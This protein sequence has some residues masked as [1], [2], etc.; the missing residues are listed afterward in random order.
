MIVD[1]KEPRNKNDYMI[2]PEMPTAHLILS[3]GSERNLPL[4]CKALH[5]EMKNSSAEIQA[6]IRQLES[7]YVNISA[8]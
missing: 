6:K 3:D 8:I 5:E 2:I 1:V 4:G 7:N